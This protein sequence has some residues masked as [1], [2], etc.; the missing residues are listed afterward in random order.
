MPKT[1]IKKG[2]SKSLTT[3]V[4]TAMSQLEYNKKIQTAQPTSV[5]AK[6]EAQDYTTYE[7]QITMRDWIMGGIPQKVE[8]IEGWLRKGMGVQS[9]EEL[10]QQALV[11]LR[12]LFPDQVAEDMTFEQ[13]VAVT[14]DIAE[15]HTNSFKRSS[16]GFLYIESRQVKAMLKEAINIR[17][18]KERVGHG[19]GAKKFS[20]ERIF[21][22][23]DIISLGVKEPSGRHLFVGHVSDRL[24][25]RST[26][27]NYDYVKQPRLSFTVK[28]QSTAVSVLEPMWPLIWV[29]AEHNGLGALR[30]QGFGTFA[31][32]KW[33]RV[34]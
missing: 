20:E 13:A 33:E 32:T 15:S 22:S 3:A 5:F 24:G 27:T 19:K 25:E 8:L 31:V 12:Q 28:V 21:V 17:F 18:P 7:V 1:I 6:Q 11:T 23:P 30:S 14:K 16:S 4:D 34:K 29:T 2:A 26:L 10:R 9:T